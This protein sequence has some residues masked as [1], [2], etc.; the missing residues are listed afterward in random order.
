MNVFQRTRIRKLWFT[1]GGECS[2]GVETAVAERSAVGVY[3]A[4]GK[5]AAAKKPRVMRGAA[6]ADDATGAAAEAAASAHRCY[7][8]QIA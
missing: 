6:R 8:N 3:C 1:A 2:N 7:V 5:R 4:L